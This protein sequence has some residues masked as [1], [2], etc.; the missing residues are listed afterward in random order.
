M[1]LSESIFL[2]T[3]KHLAVIHIKKKHTIQTLFYLDIKLERF[4]NI[5]FM[6]IKIV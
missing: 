2:I 1:K 6:T 3:S 5:Y 4:T